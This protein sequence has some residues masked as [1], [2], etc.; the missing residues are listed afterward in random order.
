[1]VLLEALQL[2]VPVAA[3]AVDGSATYFQAVALLLD[4]NAKATDS[5]GAIHEYLSNEVL[6]RDRIEAGKQLV[7]EDFSSKRQIR[8]I[9]ERYLALLSHTAGQNKS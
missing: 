1:M 5:A 6:L 3:T 4:P 9:E 8:R 7:R 2:G